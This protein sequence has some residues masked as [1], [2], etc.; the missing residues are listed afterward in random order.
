M[1]VGR[2]LAGRYELLEKVGEGGMARVYRGRDQLL[3]RTVAVKILK[4]QMTGSAD[5]VRRFRREAQAAAGLSHPNIVNVYDVGEEG[6]TYFIVMEYVD[7]NN[8]KQYIREKGYLSPAEAVAIARQIAA[9]LVQA[10]GAGVIHRDIK[11][12]NILFSRDGKVK[13]ADFGI[14]L[15]ADGSTLTCSDDIVGSVHYFSPEQAR[16]NL[17]GKQSDLYSLGVILYEMVTG[18]VPFSGESPISVAMKH[19][20]DPVEP[21]RRLNPHIP[22]PLERIILKA[23]QK[24][25]GKR[26]PDARAF[27]DDLLLF[28]Q[29]G[30]AVALPASDLSADDGDTL[31]IKPVRQLDDEADPEERAELP[32]PKR[33]IAPLIIVLVVS[34][35]LVVGF[36]YLR[37][38]LYVPE[39]TVPPVRELSQSDAVA[40]LID[41]G[42]KVNP[43]VYYVFDDKIPVGHV[44][45]TEP[46]QWRKVRQN[47]VVDLYISKGPETMSLPD[48]FGR[49]E[50]EARR[51][52]KE[53]ELQC[54]IIREHNEA[55]AEGMVFR[56][57]PE[58]GFRLS[59]GEQVIIY[60]SQGGPP[61]QISNLIGM[62]ET[63]ARDYLEVNGLLPRLRYERADAPAGTVIGQ[64]P[65]VGKNVK[66]GQSVDIVVSKG[67]GKSEDDDD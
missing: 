21:P 42:L 22:E 56:Q 1:M 41:A 10:H 23:L 13:V 28:Q 2:V 34:F 25:P 51:L 66:K 67:N 63:E 14:A 45:R 53:M 62:T 37:G 33:W 60:V 9:A 8:L 50:S 36:I 44:V 11:P 58:A 5:F 57:V 3:K 54:E 52:L 49:T 32:A 15:A 35:I 55:V 40:V 20:Q 39:V 48:L 43:E 6:N 65:E 24:E 27:L 59:R 47:R 31:V 19:V 17:A 4:D 7:G 64:Y 12:Q 38:L 46:V 26:Y 16:G 29:K 18:Q 61:F 30:T